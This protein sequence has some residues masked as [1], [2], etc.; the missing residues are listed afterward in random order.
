M[1]SLLML[2][3]C[4]ISLSACSSPPDT[5]GGKVV[6]ALFDISDSTDRQEIREKY[7]TSFRRVLDKI[8]PGDYIVAD[9]ISD[10]P[11][12]Q[13]AFPINQA[14]PY[15]DP[16]TDNE[17]VK[18][19][20]REE[21]DNQLAQTRA[22][23][24]EM[25]D[26]LL[27]DQNRQVRQTKILDAVRLADRVFHTYKRPRNV[28]VV[29]SDMIEESEKANFERQ[30]PDQSATASLLDAERSGNRLPDLKGVKIYV[31]GASAGNARSSVDSYTRIQNFWMEYFRRT[32]ADMTQERY[33]AALI[34]F[35]EQ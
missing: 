18:R 6:V 31:V 1:R 33:G 4:V 15:F 34:D 20:K 7:A 23:L 26:K 19:K 11:L 21:F 13:S 17:L 5:E 8:G 22:N 16:G 32:G 14:I 3:A 12:S 24:L 30:P 28:L 25:T 35:N 2:I 27:G 9:L 10:D 29:F